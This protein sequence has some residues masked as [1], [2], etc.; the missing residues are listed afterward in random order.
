MT[1]RLPTAHIDIP[2]ANRAAD[3]AIGA[4]EEAGI[5]PIKAESNPMAHSLMVSWCR[6]EITR[7]RYR[8]FPPKPPDG[9]GSRENPLSMDDMK[10]LMNALDR[11][12]ESR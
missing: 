11:M 2:T 4:L 1:N 8:L 5:D 12:G 3:L 6:G 10:P 7:T 9:K